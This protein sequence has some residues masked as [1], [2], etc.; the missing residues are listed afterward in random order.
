MNLNRTN[1]T[2]VEQPRT[3]EK[4]SYIYA[5]ESIRPRILDT[6]LKLEV[7]PPS[8][9][10]PPPPPPLPKGIDLSGKLVKIIEIQW[11]KN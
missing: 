10:G 8:G 4:P 11:L 2:N 1:M 6:P 5:R 3:R 9:K 7:Q